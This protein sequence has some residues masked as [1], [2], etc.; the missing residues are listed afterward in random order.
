MFG[1]R[2]GSAKW[3]LNNFVF[4]RAIPLLASFFKCPA[5]K[6]FA[7]ALDELKTKKKVFGRLTINGRQELEMGQ[8]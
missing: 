1:S 8:T 3:T 4:L 7:W 5:S 2:E 6:T